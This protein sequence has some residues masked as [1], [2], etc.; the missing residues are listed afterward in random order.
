MQQDSKCNSCGEEKNG[1]CGAEPSIGPEKLPEN[2]LSR[3]L[4]NLNFCC[5]SSN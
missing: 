4:S 3:Y 1:G 5:S 2:D